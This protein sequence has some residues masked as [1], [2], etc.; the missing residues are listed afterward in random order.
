VSEPT[1]TARAFEVVFS[2]ERPDTPIFQRAW[3]H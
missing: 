2:S 1:V 3:M